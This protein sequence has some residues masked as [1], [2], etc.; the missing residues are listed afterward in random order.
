LFSVLEIVGSSIYIHI[1][2]YTELYIMIYVRVL[3]GRGVN[4]TSL[5]DESSR[6]LSWYCNSIFSHFSVMMSTWCFI[7]KLAGPWNE[8]TALLNT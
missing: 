3:S 7:G 5:K 2:R 4:E 1:H 6:S 8:L